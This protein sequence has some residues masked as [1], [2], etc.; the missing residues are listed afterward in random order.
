MPATAILPPSSALPPAPVAQLHDEAFDPSRLGAYHLD[1]LLTEGHCR[2][3]VREAARQKVVVLEDWTLAAASA[4]PA[5]AAGH[6]LLGRAGWAGVRLAVGGGAFTLLPAPLFRPGDEAAYLGLH[7]T[8]GATEQALAYALPPGSPAHEL[9][10]IFGTEAAVAEWLQAT[11]GPTARLLHHT[12]A[13]VAGLLHQRGPAAPTRQLYLHLA[14]PELTL[15]VLGTQLE[16]C[17][18]FAI[19][20][21]EDAVYYTILVMQELGLNPDQ[22]TVTI[23][24]DLTSESAIFTLLRT[25]VRHLRFGSRPFGLQYSYRL[26]ELAEC[27]HFELFSLAFCD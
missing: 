8:L 12:S 19:S 4:L 5:L 23:W 10:S 25:Y 3:T 18:V 1:I 17:N 16:F 15:V 7:Y 21:P 9:V 26:N 22:D 6:E 2:L 14:G 24:G 13:L 27:R 11:H 20:T